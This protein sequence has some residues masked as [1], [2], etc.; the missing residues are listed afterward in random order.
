M[1]GEDCNLRFCVLK[2]IT[3]AEFQISAQVLFS[4]DKGRQ[5]LW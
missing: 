2:A 4:W 1:I 5:G 3:Q